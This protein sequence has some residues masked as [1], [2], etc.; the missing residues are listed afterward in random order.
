MNFFVT[1][2]NT[3]CHFCT[4]YG[5]RSLTHRTSALLL[6]T[7]MESW[8]TLITCHVP[9][10]T[11]CYMMWHKPCQLK[12]YHLQHV[13]NGKK[14]IMQVGFCCLSP[15]SS[16]RSYL[17]FLLSALFSSSLTHTKLGGWKIAECLE[18][19][20]CGMDCFLHMLVWL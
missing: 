4:C 9:T 14:C 3:P 5:K 18:F 16:V 20:S 10:N 7:I 17:F 12:V 1:V 19:T 15:S 11:I 13:S 2:I 6:V 8:D